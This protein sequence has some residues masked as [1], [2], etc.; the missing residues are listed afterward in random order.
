MTDERSLAKARNF[1]IWLEDHGLLVLD[2]HFEYE[3]G[4]AQGMGY[5]VDTAFLMRFLVAFGVDHLQKVNGKSCWVTH[6]NDKISKI[7]PL[8]KKDGEAFDIPTWRE[9]AKKQPGVSPYEMRTG[10]KP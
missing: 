6:T 9:W 4:G 7:E 5:C 3:D 10:K 2:G 8:H 1:D